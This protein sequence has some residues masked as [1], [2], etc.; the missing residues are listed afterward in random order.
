MRPLFEAEG[1]AGFELGMADLEELQR[2]HAACPAYYEVALGGPPGP[3]AARE[4]LTRLPPPEF[5]FTRKW[6]IGFRDGGDGFVAMADV[7]EDLLAPRVW[8]VGLFLVPEPLHGT[9]LARRAYGA[10]E[11]WM[12]SRGAQWLR[13]GVIEGNARAERFWRSFGYGE[14]RRRQA[15]AMGRRSN[16]IIVMAKPLAGGT[17]ADYLVLVAR[18]RPETP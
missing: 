4:T 6:T 14:T 5:P 17:L 13:L 11:R 16:T 12:E 7:I 18:D 1:L 10:L 9:G 2:V 15:V 3:E 8:H